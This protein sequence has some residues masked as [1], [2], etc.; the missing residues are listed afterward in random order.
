MGA[1]AWWGEP[2]VPGCRMNRPQSSDTDE[3]HCVLLPHL[4]ITSQGKGKGERATVCFGT[5]M[6]LPRFRKYSE[7]LCGETR[8]LHPEGRVAEVPVSHPQR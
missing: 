5:H 2:A 7:S 3:K 6:F 1:A 8:V 4:L